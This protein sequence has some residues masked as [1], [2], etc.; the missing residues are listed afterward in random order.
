V[1]ARPGAA[2]KALSDLA[3]PANVADIHPLVIR[4]NL[5]NIIFLR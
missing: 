1:A 4:I 2:V 5:I 3:P